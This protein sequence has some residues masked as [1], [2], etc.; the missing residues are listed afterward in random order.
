MP[1]ATQV[2]V[3]VM[4]ALIGHVVPPMQLG[5]IGRDPSRLILRQQLRRRSSPGLI[6]EKDV[7]CERK[8]LNL[9]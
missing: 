8:R 9:P 1:S 6:L 4:S 3:L 7:A 2:L 5:N